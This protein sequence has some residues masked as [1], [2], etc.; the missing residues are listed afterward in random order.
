M[1]KNVKRFFRKRGIWKSE[2]VN[3]EVLTATA[4]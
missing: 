1:N 3:E 2:E 4:R